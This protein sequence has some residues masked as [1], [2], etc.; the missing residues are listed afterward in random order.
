MK[1][2][3]CLITGLLTWL[4]MNASAYAITA[5]NGESYQ[6]VVRSHHVTPGR[7][8][9][10]SAPAFHEMQGVLESAKSFS[11]FTSPQLVHNGMKKFSGTQEVLSEKLMCA[12]LYGLIVVSFMRNNSGCI[13]LYLQHSELLI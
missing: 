5:S 10:V 11:G 7:F 12:A 8:T 6:F 4:L 9:H 2:I 13:V 1:K 3:N